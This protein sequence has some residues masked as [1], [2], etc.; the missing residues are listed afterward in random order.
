MSLSSLN[1]NTV[2]Y[3][4]SYASNSF[5]TNYGNQIQFTTLSYNLPSLST[6]GPNGLTTTSV[7][8]GGNIT[9]DGGAAITSRGVCWATTINPTIL[10]SKTEDGSGSGLF[11]SYIDGL[12]TNNTYYIRAYATNSVGTSYGNQQTLTNNAVLPTNPAIPIVGTSSSNSVLTATTGSSGGYVSQNGGSDLIAK[13]VCWS[14]SENPT[15]ADSHTN[16]GSGL[17]FF[18]EYDYRA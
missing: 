6:A 18:Y 10:N 7:N 12:A 4:R 5:G 14:L 16:D 9:N 17:G 13:G 2:Y 3:A 8:S 15:I 1:S 11:N